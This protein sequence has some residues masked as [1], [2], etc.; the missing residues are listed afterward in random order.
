MSWR[1]FWAFDKL[2][3]DAIDG[4]VKGPWLALWALDKRREDAIDE[5]VKGTWLANKPPG[6]LPLTTLQAEYQVT[7]MTQLAETQMY[8]QRYNVLLVLHAAIFTGA[9]LSQGSIAPAL[10]V[11][12]L[13]LSVFHLFLNCRA[14]EYSL[15]YLALAKKC[16]TALSG[17]KPLTAMAKIT[18]KFHRLARFPMHSVANLIVVMALLAYT[19]MFFRPSWFVPA[20]TTKIHLSVPR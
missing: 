7:V 8:W 19:A 4:A 17:G 15:A 16:E 3:K 1:W 14:R 13:V 9:V 2:R 18:P 11:M 6:K 20:D 12:G 5:A 10:P